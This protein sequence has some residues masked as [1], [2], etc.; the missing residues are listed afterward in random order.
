MPD[1]ILRKI[2]LI[3]FLLCAAVQPATAASMNRTFFFGRYPFDAGGK[4]EPL[5]W[6][7]LESPRFGSRYV[8][9]ATRYGIEARSFDSKGRGNWSNSELRQWLDNEFIKKAFTRDEAAEIE[10]VT[11]MSLNY[12][13][14]FSP[15]QRMLEP[16]P[17]AKIRGA[18]VDRTTGTSP[19]WVLAGICYGKDCS[20]GRKPILTLGGYMGTVVTA[21]G[22]INYVTPVASIGS[23]PLVRPVIRV[24]SYVLEGKN[25][26]KLSGKGL[27][28]KEKTDLM[29]NG[30]ID[31]GQEMSSVVS[32]SSRLQVKKCQIS[33]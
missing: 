6:V 5:E 22:G 12:I 27:S 2:Y 18:R 17:Y 21:N 8:Y 11:L 33:L 9:L 24:R 4:V 32:N 13:L 7:V 23:H 14:S 16:T 19:W 10:R 20:G 15:E 26:Y 31:D 30:Y 3:L 1:G 28:S 25:Y 29:V